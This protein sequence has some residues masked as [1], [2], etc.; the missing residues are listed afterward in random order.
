MIFPL[1]II[2]N[3]GGNFLVSSVDQAL[4]FKENK[5]RLTNTRT[6]LL[7]VLHLPKKAGLES[8]AYR[9]VSP[10]FSNPDI[11]RAGCKIKD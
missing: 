8:P 6:L 5:V 3:N 2:K 10:G 11:R 1:G 4:V 9:N 7:I